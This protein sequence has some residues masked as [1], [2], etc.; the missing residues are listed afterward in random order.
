MN[1]WDTRWMESM[2]KNK[3][4]IKKA[5]R[6]MDDLRAILKALKPGWRWL[7]GGLWFCES[8]RLEDMEDGRSNCRRTGDVLLASMNE[9]M[10][11]LVFTLEIHEDFQD[12]KLPTLDTL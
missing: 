3:I 7:E 1:E 12:Q 11:F 8:W 4:E 5:E 10:H 9:I 6:Y 2:A